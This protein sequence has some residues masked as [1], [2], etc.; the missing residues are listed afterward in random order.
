LVQFEEAG[1][2]TFYEVAFVGEVVLD[3]GLLCLGLDILGGVFEAEEE[4][5]RVFDIL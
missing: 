1:V 4:S 2:Q 3:G 5:S